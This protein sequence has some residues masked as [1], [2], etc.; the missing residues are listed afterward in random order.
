MQADRE[1]Y[2]VEEEN[3]FTIMRLETKEFSFI[4]DPDKEKN[5]SLSGDKDKEKGKN[6]PK[7]AE[8]L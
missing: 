1:P 2:V 5:L 4:P 6:D 3:Q 8:L 7:P